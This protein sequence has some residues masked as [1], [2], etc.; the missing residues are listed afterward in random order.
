MMDVTVWRAVRGNGGPDVVAWA[1]G[2][3]MEYISDWSSFQIHE[4][5]V[6]RRRAGIEPRSSSKGR[7]A[8]VTE[9]NE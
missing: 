1:S 9:K 5:K 6:R 7:F 4:C 8:V 2:V 3:A